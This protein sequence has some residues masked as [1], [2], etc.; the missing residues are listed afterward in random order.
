MEKIGT[1][2]QLVKQVNDYLNFEHNLVCLTNKYKTLKPEVV[3]TLASKGLF[4][5]EGG[6]KV[7]SGLR[8]F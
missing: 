3:G 7:D 1:R 4:K 6:N 8:G 2:G 5:G